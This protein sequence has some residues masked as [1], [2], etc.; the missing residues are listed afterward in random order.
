MPV[1]ESE[2]LSVYM[3]KKISQTDSYILYLF[4]MGLRKIILGSFNSK[5]LQSLLQIQQIFVG[6]LF[7][8]T[9]IH[10][11]QM[12]NTYHVICTRTKARTFKY[13]DCPVFI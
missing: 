3:G 13:C 1:E 12:I 8:A 6:Q 2:S 11:I 10:T 5:V 7:T 4:F 9:K